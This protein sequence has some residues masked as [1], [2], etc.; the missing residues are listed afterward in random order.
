MFWSTILIKVIINCYNLDYATDDF[1][2]TKIKYIMYNVQ[3]YS[4]LYN[5]RDGILLI[6]GKHL[7][8]HIIWLRSEA[9]DHET[10]STPSFCIEVPVPNQECLRSSIC[11]LRVYILSLSMILILNIGIVHTVWYFWFSFYISW[12]NYRWLLKRYKRFLC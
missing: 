6:Y 9:C 4:V 1:C 11:V 2:V 7:C 8:D 12:W 3:D 10:S 5:V